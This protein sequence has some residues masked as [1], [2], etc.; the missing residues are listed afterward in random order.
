MMIRHILL[1]VG[2]LA[3]AAVFGQ[4]NPYRGL[5]VGEFKLD[6]VNEVS[7]PLDAQNIPRAPNPAVT[8]KTFDAANLRLILHVNGRGQVSLLK[9]VAIL[10]RKA[11]TAKSE[12]DLALVTDERL[13]GSFPPQPAQRIA[14]VVFDFGDAKATAAVDAVVNAAVVTAAANV[15]AGDV[16]RQARDAAAAVITSADAAGRFAIF[17]RDTMNAAAV[18]AVSVSGQATA[19][20][21]TAAQGLRTGSFYAD[22]RGGEMIAAVEAAATTG[23]AAEKRKAAHQAA[24]DFA[25]VDNKYQR[26]IAGELF[27][28]MLLAGADAAATAAQALPRQTIT[29]ITGTAGTAPV[30]LSSADHQLAPSERI[31]ITGAP[32]QA[33]NGVHAVTLVDTGRFSLPG[34]PF[35]AGQVIT[36][37]AAAPT[38]APLTV[39]AT[40][41]GLQTGARITLSGAGTAAYNGTFFITRIDNDAFSVPVDYLDNPGTTGKW[42]SRSGGITGYEAGTA[43]GIVKITSAGHGLNNGTVITITGAGAAVYN[44]SFPI[45]RVDANAFT[46]AVAFAG[47]PAAKGGWAVLNTIG[48]FAPPAAVP[49][50]VTRAAHGLQT[51]DTIV[52]AGAG[53]EAY[54]SNHV[55]ERVDADRFIIPVT[56][57]AADG[58]PP[59]KGSWTVP[60]GGTWRRLGPVE[61]AAEARAPVSTARA[62][63][64]RVKIAAY[65]DTRG[66]DAIAAVLAAVAAG[67]TDSA[68]SS[69]LAIKTE[70]ENAGRRALADLV[71]RSNVSRQVPTA[72]YT[73]FIRA[74]DTRFTDF[75][76][77][78]TLVAAAAAA[79]A[80]EENVNPLATA[81]SIQNKAKE[82]A[83]V[84]VSAVYATA[85]R[86]LRPELP[87]SGNFGPGASGLAGTIILP[88][89]HPTNPFRHRRHPDHTTGFDITRLVTLDFDGGAGDSLTATGFGVDSITGIYREEIHGLYKPLGPDKSLGLRVRGTFTLQRLSLIDALN[90]R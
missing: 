52:I 81:M 86:A 89:N 83:I 26:F 87:M 12:H 70:A 69:T 23:T 39:Q 66:T 30:V 47:N 82:R 49:T 68:G 31:R 43:G 79:G 77:M 48:G 8:T 84:A 34:V 85:A 20:Q 15:T 1:A 25:D 21:D 76:E 63:A 73:S 35:H 3:P 88:A 45:T 29:A 50:M 33:Y 78:A 51:G 80:V 32:I 59:V 19:A 14:S 40:A 44:G 16:E 62:E 65:E 61:T 54:N 41:H 4:A 27:G 72:D 58:N 37:Y 9:Q 11:G 13:Y 22:T 2:L 7:V 74:D 42:A 6:G 46:V 24:A 38:P 55:V 57:A 56:F 67:A 10:N 17:L 53:K 90:A 18:T 60:A 5:W 28:E 64:L 75:R 36:G 71:A